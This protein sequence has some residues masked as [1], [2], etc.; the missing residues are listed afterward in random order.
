M[1]RP[2]GVILKVISKRVAQ[3]AFASGLIALGVFGI[4]NGDWAQEWKFA[5]AWLPGHQ[6]LAYMT[7]ALMLACGAG[8]LW[9]R[10][11]AISARVLVPY[12]AV[13]LLLLKVPTV[14]KHPL[15][16][17]AWQSMS[18]VLV[19]FSAACVLFAAG[20]TDARGVRIAQLVFGAALIPF[21]LSHFAYV[22]QTAPLI[23]AWLPFHTA[24]AYGT[25]AAQVAAG[26]GV[27]LG[28]YARLAAA[29]QAALLTLFT[30]L[31]WIPMIIAK[32]ASPDL[33]SE[34]TMSWA[35]AAGAWVVAA[36]FPDR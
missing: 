31:V 13:V 26:T 1:T 7:A 24:L 18:E 21:G 32:P 33:W 20:K 30:T 4:A 11:E 6:P 12:W 25:G 15:V 29:L 19:P 17:V 3:F 34:F 16:E 36:S 35:I 22:A 14:V 28:I 23:P 10:T 2:A 27:L 5:P 9:K 8:L